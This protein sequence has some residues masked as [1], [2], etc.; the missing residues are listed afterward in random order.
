MHEGSIR[1]VGLIKNAMQ[2]GSK[3]LRDGVVSPMLVSTE[4]RHCG[5]MK[6]GSTEKEFVAMT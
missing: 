1:G 3:E 4:Q 2:E 5:C 6:K